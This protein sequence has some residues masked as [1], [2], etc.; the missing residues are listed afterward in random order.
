MLIINIVHWEL[1]QDIEVSY[2]LILIARLETECI[3]TLDIYT[4]FHAV[5]WHALSISWFSFIA[6]CTKMSMF[7]KEKFYMEFS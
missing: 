6:F 1:F 2:A 4:S 5:R 7:Y 3:M